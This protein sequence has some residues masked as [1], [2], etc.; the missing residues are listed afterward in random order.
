MDKIIKEYEDF[1]KASDKKVKGIQ[2]SLRLLKKF[3]DENDIELFYLTHKEAQE[4]QSWLNNQN[5]RFSPASIQGIIGPLSKMYDY[6]TRRRLV[7]T[8]PFLLIDRIKTPFKIPKNIPNEK[9]MDKLLTYLSKFTRGKNLIEYKRD[10]KAHVLCELLYSTGIRICEASSIKLDD[11]DLVNGTILINDSK[12]SS[13]RTVFLSDYINRILQIYISE[14]RDKTLWL[15]NGADPHL[16]FGC[17]ANL[18]LWLN[19]ILKNSCI[20]IGL[21]CITS[22]IF[23]HAFGYHMLKAGCDLRKIQSFLG[24]K[25][26]NTTQIYTKVDTET[27]RNVLDQ[28]HPRQVK[29]L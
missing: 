15:H 14:L 28:Y 7:V 23:R 13:Q 21:E 5:N 12:T 6:F 2:Y 20:E 1:L 24:H 3:L 8:N 10:Y 9:E 11:I 25:R 27:L 4:F 18:M 22:H 17:S 29:K 19:K 26:L 16:L